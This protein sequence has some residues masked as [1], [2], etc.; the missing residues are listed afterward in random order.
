MDIQHI[1]C[2]REGYPF[3]LQQLHDPPKTLYYKG[4]LP[5]DNQ[6]LLA[7]V[8]SRKMT[9]YGKSTLSKILPPVIRAGV[10]IVSGLAY[11][12]DT[13]ALTLAI[14]HGGKAYG[15]IGSGLDDASFYP[16]QNIIL[17][18]QMILK[19]GAILSEY[20]EGT[21]AL[22]QNFAIRNRIVAGLCQGSLIIEA[23]DRS[24]SLITAQVAMNENREVCTIPQSIFER[25]SAGSNNLLKHGAH[26]VTEGADILSILG[27]DAVKKTEENLPENESLLHSMLSKKPMH[28]DSIAKELNLTVGK[29]SAILSKLEIKG[30]VKNIGGMNYIKNNE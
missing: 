27:V 21:P 26:L 23:A 2:G 5:K 18:S 22:P 4:A 1:A 12:V 13:E 3:L 30:V 10:G 7:V 25:G 29:V 28:I 14:E 15:V 11:G 16:K 8:G 9:P 17:A 6:V 20:N 24:G 19:G